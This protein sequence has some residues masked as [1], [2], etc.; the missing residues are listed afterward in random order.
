VF[1]HRT[2]KIG[3]TL[4]VCLSLAAF[5]LAQ[6]KPKTATAPM[7]VIVFPNYAYP[8]TI[9]SM[10][11]FDAKNAPL[12]LFDDS[13]KPATTA[14][15]QNGV[16][17]EHQKDGGY[18]NIRFTDYQYFEYFNEQPNHAL[19][20][21]TWSTAGPSGTTAIGLLQVFEVRDGHPVVTEQIR[22]NRIGDLTGAS[23]NPTTLAL[24]VKANRWSEHATAANIEVGKFRWDGKKFVLQSS[25]TP[26]ARR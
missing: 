4:L 1:L 16:F 12:A 19:A 20:A 3:L 14:K 11:E 2:Q 6:S 26:A 21:I 7:F 8:Q 5:V 18:T 24:T 25:A 10:L 23:F 17:D 22:Y 13:G 9:A 15:L